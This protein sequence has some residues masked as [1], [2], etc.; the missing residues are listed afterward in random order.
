MSRRA[1]YTGTREGGPPNVRDRDDS[2]GC[3]LGKPAEVVKAG[4]G[5][6]LPCEVVP[7]LFGMGAC[8]DISFHELSEL[9]ISTGVDYKPHIA[10]K[11]QKRPR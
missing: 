10:Q 4:S 2:A 9:S 11:S 1:P 5:A 8:R 7:K 6:W 3:E